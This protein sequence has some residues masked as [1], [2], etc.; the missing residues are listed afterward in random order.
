MAITLYEQN[1]L[2]LGTLGPDALELPKV[3]GLSAQNYAISFGTSYKV[4][5]NAANEVAAAYLNKMLRV[6]LGVSR[7][8]E[9]SRFLSS[10]IDVIVSIIATSNFDY[11]TIDA[12]LDRDWETPSDTHNILFK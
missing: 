4:F 11:A 8:Q 7:S 6:S 3:I 5:D 10:I 1:E 12:A 2:L 9:R